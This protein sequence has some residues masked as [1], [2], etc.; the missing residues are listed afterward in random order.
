MKWVFRGLRDPVCLNV[1]FVTTLSSMT[2]IRII[3]LICNFYK[4]ANRVSIWPN[5]TGSSRSTRTWETGIRPFNAFL[6]FTN[7]ITRAVRINNTFWATTSNCIWFGYQTWLASTNGIAHIV[8]HT[9]SSRSTWG[10][11]TRIWFFYT[12][13]IFTNI[14]G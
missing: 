8:G 11:V 13:L 6:I 1:I 4:P 7:K 2:L 3:F 5:T 9:N 10:W 12:S 14:S